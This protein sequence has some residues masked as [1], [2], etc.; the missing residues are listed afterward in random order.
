MHGHASSFPSYNCSYTLH[1][2]VVQVLGAMDMAESRLGFIHNDM[3]IA[4]VMEHHKDAMSMP[5]KGY[6]SKKQ[7]KEYRKHMKQPN[8]F[9]LAGKRDKKTAQWFKLAGRKQS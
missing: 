9:K 1:S 3:R 7:Q 8:V 6:A 2:V 4:N 5:P